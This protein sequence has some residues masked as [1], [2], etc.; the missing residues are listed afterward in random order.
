MNFLYNQLYYMIIT[1]KLIRYALLLFPN[2]I[3][4]DHS[5]FSDKVTKTSL[6][7]IRKPSSKTESSQEIPILLL[8]HYGYIQIPMACNCSL[9]HGQN[10]SIYY[11]PTNSTH[12]Q[13]SYSYQTQI[14]SSIL[15][16]WTLHPSVPKNQ[17]QT[18]SVLQIFF[19]WPIQPK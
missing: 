11:C 6:T 7:P 10:N 1:P 12:G 5:P 17:H 2:K 19:L 18:L 9:H 4:A 14:S 13:Q 16:L 3:P 8:Y 15:L